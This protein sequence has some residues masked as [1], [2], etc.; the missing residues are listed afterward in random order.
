MLLLKHL[1]ECMCI[2][3]AC[4]YHGTFKLFSILIEK[5]YFVCYFVCFNKMYT[6]AALEV[7]I[8][9]S[10]DYCSSVLIVRMIESTIAFSSHEFQVQSE[11]VLFQ[12]SFSCFVLDWNHAIYW[13]INL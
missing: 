10:K 11:V 12:R 9:S 3:N 6:N 1:D 13:D 4:V 7:M 5:I 8:D 2:L